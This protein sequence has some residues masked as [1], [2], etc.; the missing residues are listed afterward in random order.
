MCTGCLK[1]FE[2][3]FNILSAGDKYVMKFQNC[4]GKKLVYIYEII[5]LLTF[6]NL[7]FLKFL[8][9]PNGQRWSKR[10]ISCYSYKIITKD[11]IHVFLKLN[12]L[13]F[14]EN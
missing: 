8:Y 3:C 10:Q 7:H 2:K 12:D 11:I 13:L 14:F 4:Y 1:K 9:D 6:I 5:M